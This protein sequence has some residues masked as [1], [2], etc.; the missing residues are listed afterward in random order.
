MNVNFRLLTDD[1]S[2]A[3]LTNLLHAAYAQLGALGFNYTAVDQTE[4][5]TRDR[6]AGGECYVAQKDGRLVGTILFRDGRHSKGC[7]WFDRPY[8]STFH[9]FGVLPAFQNQGI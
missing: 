6:I 8:V 5:V 1:D 7:A 4:N 3:E 9:Q 2:L